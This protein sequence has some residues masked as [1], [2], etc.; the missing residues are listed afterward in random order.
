MTTWETQGLDALQMGHIRHY[1]NLSRQLP[2][3]WS[4]MKGRGVGQ[5]DF[6]GYR[7]QLAYM[8]YALA[9]VHRHRLPAAPAVFQPIMKRLIDKLLLPEVWMYWHNVSRGGSVFNAHLARNYKEEWD[10]VGRD[11]IMYSAYVQSLTLLYHYLFDD[12]VY[13]Q[14]GSL[15]FRFWSYFWGGEA[16]EFKYD[17]KSLNDH[18][19]WMMVKS[20]YI[21]V[22]CE[23]N[24][25]FQICNQPA[26]LGFRMHDLV[27][28]GSIAEEVTREYEAAWKE[29]GRIG[30]NGH[31]HIMLAEDTRV[32]RANAA[33]YPWVDAWLGTLMNMWNREFVRE[34]YPR[35][36]RDYLIGSADGL[37]SVRSTPR[38]SIKGE[39]VVND[40]CDFGWVAAWAS[41]MG[42]EE[43]LSGLLRYADRYL[44][45]N[46]RDGGLYYPRN[47]V[48][49]DEFGS[50]LLVEPQTGNVLLGYSR[51]NVADGLWKLYNEPW[52]KERFKQ[53]A[54]REAADDIDVS[55]A[56]Y[57]AADRTLHLA[58]GRSRDR[59]GTGRVGL[60]P[61]PSEA[62]WALGCDGV[63]VA[64]GRGNE[65][66]SSAFDTL[67]ASDGMIRFDC[68]G[69]PSRSFR[70][71]LL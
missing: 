27:Y 31:Y 59:K 17:Q 46:W 62:R 37:L 36:V 33:A 24:C 11:N 44:S 14:E 1:D 58:M 21:G 39:T 55:V 12:P 30:E 6:G 47:D 40:D 34:N 25:V 19:Y 48:E 54:F 10:P 49:G 3:D 43:T 51:L 67:S 60:G 42:D 45:P 35:Q 18:L 52:S 2:N 4:L 38:P 64:L 70:L 8:A 5:D 22:A 7:F 71:A 26:I 23:P 69:G 57:D 68:A 53:P 29:F 9:L 56:F 15:T 50:R 61:V 28:G 32:P 65:I 13:E 16:K 66:L 63:E 20:G 41:E